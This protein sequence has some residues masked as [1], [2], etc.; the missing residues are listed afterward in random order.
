[1]IAA[2][3]GTVL[4]VGAASA[5]VSVGGVGYEVHLSRFSA[6]RMPGLGAVVFLHVQMVVREDAI[7]LYAFVEPAEKEM[8]RLL[9]T[10]SGVGPKLALTILSGMRAAEL[11]RAI[12][13][14]DVRLLATLPGIGLKTAQRLCVEL[15]DKAGQIIE[16]P[17]EIGVQKSLLARE[18]VTD[19]ISALE[20]LGY[21]RQRAVQ[22]L[23]QVRRE[24]GGDE[25][26]MTGVAELLRRSLRALA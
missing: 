13:T 11:G 24:M 16:N 20:N 5:V 14:D 7:T 25:F 4:A 15:K 22:I 8:F 21:T 9:T 2:L 18:V 3:E 23:E 1:M 12:V 10:V 6:S 19:V 26:E 17:G